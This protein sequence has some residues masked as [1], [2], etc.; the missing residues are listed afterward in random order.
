MPVKFSEEYSIDVA[1]LDKMSVFDVILDVD[2]RVF[3]DPALLELTN[4]QEFVGARNKISEYF[5]KIIILL[6]HSKT[7]GDMFWVEADKSLTFT[8]LTGT[9]FGYSQK[10]TSGNGIG[11]VLRGKVLSTVK[12][13]IE[14]G[15]EDPIIFELLG[16]FQEKIG[17]DRISDL[18]TYILRYEIFAYTERVIDALGI[19]SATF[20]YSNTSYRACLN[21]YNN[22]PLLLIPKEILSPLP[23]SESL[24]D[25]D[26]ICSTNE[27]VRAD[28]NR[29]IDLKGERKL[30][31]TSISK[32]MKEVPSFR[33]L[34]FKSY[35]SFPKSVY[36]FKNDPSGEYIW[37]ETSRRFVSEFPFEESIKMPLDNQSLF[38]VTK[39]ICIKFKE[40]IE[41]NGLND[42]LYD[43]RKYPKHERAAQL[44]F[45]GIADAYCKAWNIDLSPE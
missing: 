36:D 26:I 11:S 21:S 43:R 15:E 40:L 12:E 8:E 2:T 3:L 5:S 24:N 45:F 10:G 9:C 19:P 44:L 41:D 29:I 1:E 4:Q 18:I 14:A 6:K 31:K 25:I 32:L 30:S 20:Y 7:K 27:R 37:V 42:L 22:K 39:K 17:C 28:I 33:G 35:H 34:L 13:L 23:V 38:S 16:V